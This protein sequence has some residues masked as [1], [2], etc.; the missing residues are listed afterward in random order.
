MLL[1]VLPLS[2][3]IMLA[4]ILANPCMR[5]RTPLFIRSHIESAPMLKMLSNILALNPQREP[6]YHCVHIGRECP[7]EYGGQK[8]SVAFDDGATRDVSS[9]QWFQGNAGFRTHL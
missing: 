4:V 7:G 1:N 5:A 9:H 3:A 6:H 8:D 2:L